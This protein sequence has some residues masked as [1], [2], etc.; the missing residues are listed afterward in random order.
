[1]RKAVLSA[2]KSKC[3]W[4]VTHTYQATIETSNTT[5]EKSMQLIANWGCLINITEKVRPHVNFEIVY[6]N[7]NE[8]F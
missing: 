1:M 7:D 4:Y 8:P 3:L 6:T 5:E 2:A